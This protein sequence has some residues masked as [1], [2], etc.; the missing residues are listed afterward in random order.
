[1]NLRFLA[2]LTSQ[3]PHWKPP[4]WSSVLFLWAVV[5]VFFALGW[6]ILRRLVARADRLTKA[7][8]LR[9]KEEREKFIRRGAGEH[10]VLGSYTFWEDSRSGESRWCCEYQSHL[11]GYSIS[12][13]GSGSEPTS[14]KVERLQEMERR[15][16]K[17]IAAIPPPDKDDGWGH[18][19]TNYYAS[20]AVINSVTVS[21]DLS[22]E[23]AVSYKPRPEGHYCL[24]PIV[25]ATSDWRISAY[26]TV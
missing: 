19:F 24:S 20:V 1:M 7:R 8:A 25:D 4:S 17:I 23:I 14:A 10:P 16:Q 26:W 13:G 15:A 6:L 11:L 18:S 9:W 12:V 21:D 2:A 3:T 5:L 22:L